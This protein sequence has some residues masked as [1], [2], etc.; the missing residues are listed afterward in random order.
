MNCFFLVFYF[1][2]MSKITG[3]KRVL[4]TAAEISPENQ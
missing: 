4:I 1:E 3:I 2:L